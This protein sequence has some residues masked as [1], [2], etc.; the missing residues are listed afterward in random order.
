MSDSDVSVAWIDADANGQPK[1]SAEAMRALFS[2]FLQPGDKPL[3]AKQ[4]VICGLETTVDSGQVIVGAGAAVVDFARGSFIV[5]LLREKRLPVPPPH[6]SYPRKDIIVATVADV[7]AGRGGDIKLISGTPS[8]RPLQPVAPAGSITLA[9]V[10]VPV[11]GEISLS[12]TAAV[13]GVR[14]DA[15]IEK[16]SLSGG[17]RSGRVELVTS[18][19]DSS[20]HLTGVVAS[21]VR[22]N[23]ARTST[24][25]VGSALLRDS[26]GE[27]WIGDVTGGYV[28]VLGDPESGTA[29][30]GVI[31]VK[32]A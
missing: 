5:L 18:A 12:S 9:H 28:R 6:A 1:Y 20:L 32:E 25:Y 26:R 13:S 27:F 14:G 15:S 10:D 4:G 8:S 16:L 17:A 30:T 2:L 29:V 7:G 3:T 24:E 31:P 23:W 22:A 11:R 19:A 21:G